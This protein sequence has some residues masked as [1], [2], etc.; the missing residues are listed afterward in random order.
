[1]RAGKLCAA[2]PLTGHSH[3]ELTCFSPAI[4]LHPLQAG[5]SP[6]RCF[7]GYDDPTLRAANR[8][9][10][11][12]RTP[13]LGTDASLT[14]WSNTDSCSRPGGC[15]VRRLR[16]GLCRECNSNADRSVIVARPTCGKN[17]LGQRAPAVLPHGSSATAL[18]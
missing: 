12:A 15:G 13:P 1:R 2:S 16:T 4:H 8:Y 6:G 14:T 10:W 11:L 7:A 5:L 17:R 3:P 18:G 9:T